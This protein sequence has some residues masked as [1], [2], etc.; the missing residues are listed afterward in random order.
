MLVASGVDEIFAQFKVVK[1]EEV[2]SLA[3]GRQ[4]HGKGN[5]LRNSNVTVIQ[6]MPVE[7][8]NRRTDKEIRRRTEASDLEVI[9]V[10]PMS[11]NEAINSSLLKVHILN[12]RTGKIQDAIISSDDR[13]FLKPFH[14]KPAGKGKSRDNDRGYC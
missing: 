4:A 3:P 6:M 9:T 12:V 11:G 10:V 2:R 7:R 1:M 8:M 5:F 14:K 13:S